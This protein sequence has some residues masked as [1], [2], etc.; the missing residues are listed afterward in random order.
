VSFN[1]LHLGLEFSD[2]AVV[3]ADA[4]DV[5][6]ERVTWILLAHRS[7]EE[8]R[9]EISL[10]SSFEDGY[11]SGWYERILLSPVPVDKDP[12]EVSTPESPDIEI[13][14]KRKA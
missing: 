11:I 9:C 14:I 4:N 5:A 12:I 2:Q 10:P 13:S 6:P 1:Q 7:G 8:V 3:S